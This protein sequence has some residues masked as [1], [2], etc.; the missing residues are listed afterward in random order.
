MMKY[1][2]RKINVKKDEL[3]AKIKENKEKHIE[4]FKKAVV[5]Y[6]EEAEKQL[7]KEMARLNTDGA[8][9]IKLDLITPVNN[10]DNYDKI[11]QMFEREVAE[12]V[13][14]QQDEF[15]EYVQDEFDFAVTARMSNS[16]YLMQ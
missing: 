4:E 11:L 14:L 3:I 6:K 1:G 10:A 15:K 16:A 5:A 8:L 13:E 7:M 2:N 9:D 12:V